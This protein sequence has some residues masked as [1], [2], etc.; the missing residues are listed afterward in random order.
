[1]R[2]GVAVA[3]VLATLLAALPPAS[4]AATTDVAISGFKFAPAEIDVKVGDTVRWTNTDGSDHTATSTAGGFD[5]T[6]LK[7]GGTGAHRF[8]VEGT[9][10]V[11]CRFHSSMTSLVHVAAVPE[12]SAPAVTLAAPGA[13]VGGL[14]NVTG[15]VTDP[16]GDIVSVN[17]R[18]DNGAWLEIPHATSAWS[19]A[20]NTRALANGAHTLTARASDGKLTTLAPTVTVQVNNAPVLGVTAPVDGM[21]ATLGA[22]IDV[23]GTASSA[24]GT[25]LTVELSIDDAPWEPAEGASEWS[26]PWNTSGLSAGDHTFQ[27][28]ASDG[29]NVA[30][31]Q[32]RRVH[33]VEAAPPEP[34]E[35]PLLDILSPSEGATVAGLVNISGTASDPDGTKPTVEIN[36]DDSGWR[37]V[38]ARVGGAWWYHW[39][40]DG[41]APGPHL[42]EVRASD[43]ASSV[44]VMR[45]IGLSRAPPPLALALAQTPREARPVTVRVLSATDPN[46]TFPLARVRLL[47]AAGA[48]VAEAATDARGNATLPALARGNYTLRAY[49]PDAQGELSFEVRPLYE[50]V[51]TPREAPFADVV[52]FT[53]SVRAEGPAAGVPAQIRGSILPG[54]ATDVGRTARSGNVTFGLQP[55]AAG[56]LQIWIGGNDTGQRVRIV[57]TVNARWTPEDPHPG[58]AITIVLSDNDA[59]RT[60]HAD[61]EVSV[62]APGEAR[63]TL[64]SDAQ[65]AIV[66]VAKNPGSL[67]LT[68]PRPGFPAVS[69]AVPVTAPPAL[70]EL[71]DLASRPGPAQLQVAVLVRNA[72]SGAGSFLVDALASGENGIAVQETTRTAVLD[73][74]QEEREI[75]TLRIGPGQYDVIASVRNSTATLH[76]TARVVDAGIPAAIVASP[77]EATAPA[78]AKEEKK[79]PAGAALAPLAVALVALASRRRRE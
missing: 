13:V 34:D 67:R 79:T 65:G 43:A 56:E 10:T 49:A 2:R 59:A 21:N 48:L 70:P 33:L 29:A 72:G 36:L 55:F 74:G 6:V 61:A 39:L 23:R 41:A 58:E 40:P 18:I 38:T 31:S 66:V 3:V 32:V 7:N 26:Y 47:D 46:A 28:R 14:Y 57:P 69:L 51:V 1:M 60:R 12:N 77:D 24:P 45:G 30:L 42:I 19:Y 78:A 17:L 9:F 5:V 11:V 16:D 15:S 73:P 71:R 75:F 20:W 64:R 27:A 76:G 50:V 53:V 37:N 8:M 25:T 52:A 62:D 44:T 4:A 54:N 63:Q 35:P 68:V 22:F